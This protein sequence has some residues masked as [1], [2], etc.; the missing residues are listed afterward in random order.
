[1]SDGL[2]DFGTSFAT[3]VS[4][5]IFDHS[6]SVMTSFESDVPMFAQALSLKGSFGQSR[7]L[8]RRSTD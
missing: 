2:P 7:V 4:R 5:T 6:C 1:M 8:S 3:A